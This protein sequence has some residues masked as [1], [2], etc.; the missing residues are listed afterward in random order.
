[1]RKKKI[2]RRTWGIIFSFLL[3]IMLNSAFADEKAASRQKITAD[4]SPMVASIL[5]K[6]ISDLN[7]QSTIQ[8]N[9]G[10][11][12]KVVFM[13]MCFNYLIVLAIASFIVFRTRVIRPPVK[14]VLRFRH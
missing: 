8:L 7:N 10:D 2:E 5:Q 4:D 3:T 14:Q 11:K 12:E 1:M 9:Q 13:A 6:H